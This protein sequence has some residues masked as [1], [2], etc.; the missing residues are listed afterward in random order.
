MNWI[1]WFACSNRYI[2]VSWCIWELPKYASWNTWIW[3][4]SFSFCTRISMASSVNMTTVKLDVS[5]DIDMPLMVEKVTRGRTCHVIH[6]YAKADNKTNTWKIM[7]KT[8]NLDVNNIYGRAISQKLIV[9]SRLKMHLSL[10][11]TL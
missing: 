4:S 5:T 9:L 6:W 1:W 2:I 11:K 8:K 7:I 10:I 3:S